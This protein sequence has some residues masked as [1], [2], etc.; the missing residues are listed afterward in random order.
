[1]LHTLQYMKF[2]KTVAEQMKASDHLKDYLAIRNKRE[3][4][5]NLYKSEKIVFEKYLSVWV[6]VC[7]LFGIILLQLTLHF[8][9]HQGQGDK[10]L[11]CNQ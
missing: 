2:N 9:A 4:F 5:E 1:M 8:A 6:A 3:K 10:A 7:I 11:Q